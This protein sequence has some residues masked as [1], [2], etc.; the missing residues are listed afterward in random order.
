MHCRL[1]VGHMW[2]GKT[3][4][5]KTLTQILQSIIRHGLSSFNHNCTSNSRE[6]MKYNFVVYSLS[7]VQL[8]VTPWAAAHQT[9]LSFT[10]S[11]S[12]LKLMS[13]KS[14]MPSNYLILCH[15][16]LLL[17]SN[18][19][20]HQGLFQWVDSS[21]QVTKYWRGFI[22]FRID[23]FDLPAVQETLKSPLQ[24]HSLKV[25]IL[26]LSAFFM[27]QLSYPYMTTGKYNW[28]C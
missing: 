3:C 15:S 8:F 19:S 4:L 27:F 11:Q 25:S 5:G 14:V 12:L 6:T 21:H 16:L 7:H 24:L 22:S 2:K 10:I 23:W 18:L 9:S 28:L 1:S 26:W 13:I 20:Q 17:P